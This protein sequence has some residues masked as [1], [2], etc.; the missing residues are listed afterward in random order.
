MNR[1]VRSYKR[2]SVQENPWWAQNKLFLAFE[3]KVLTK[4]NDASFF[5]TT[6]EVDENTKA[7]QIAVSNVFK[8]AIFLAVFSQTNLYAQYFLLQQVTLAQMLDNLLYFSSLKEE[9]PSAVKEVKT[10]VKRFSLWFS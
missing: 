2:N 9:M 6:F 8:F 4:R 5:K 1:C 7:S 3:P 10:L